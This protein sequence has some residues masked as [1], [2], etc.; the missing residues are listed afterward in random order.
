MG[1]WTWLQLTFGNEKTLVRLAQTKGD[2]TRE[3]AVMR[4]ANPDVLPHLALRDRNLWVR[5]AATRRLADGDVLLQ[6]AFQDDVPGVQ[7]DAVERLSDQKGLA[8]LAREHPSEHIRAAAVGKLT[9]Q[10]VLRTIAISPGNTAVRASALN[11]L[12]DIP[13][14]ERVGAELAENPREDADVRRAACLALGRCGEQGISKL[15][16]F[17]DYPVISHQAIEA[18]GKSGRPQVVD[19]LLKWWTGR[20]DSRNEG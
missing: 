9:D 3:R 4:L 13:V 12:S 6:I 2:P 20:R 5:S 1:L 15:L 14:L 10:A 11:Y 8:R 17:I 16:G 18:L 7:R 19:P